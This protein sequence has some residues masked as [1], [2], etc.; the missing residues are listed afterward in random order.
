MS[1]RPTRGCLRTLAHHCYQMLKLAVTFVAPT[2]STGAVQ[3]VRV[4]RCKIRE[5]SGTPVP[6]EASGV[7]ADRVPARRSDHQSQRL[8]SHGRFEREP[9]LTRRPPH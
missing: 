6:L 8:S 1:G 9:R 4:S 2:A 3:D 7:E 5:W